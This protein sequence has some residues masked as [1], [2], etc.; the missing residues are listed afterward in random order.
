MDGKLL[1]RAKERLSE[2]SRQNEQAWL[3]RRTAAFRKV[4]ELEKLE[5][6]LQSLVTQAALSALMRGQNVSA[7]VDGMAE[8]SLALQAR[9]RAL[10]RNAGLPENTLDEIYTCPKCHDTGYV[11]GDM[12]SCLQALY[13]EEARKSLSNLLKLGS[14]SFAGFDLSYY[15]TETDADRGVSPRERMRV[16][17]EYCR[18]YAQKFAPGADNLLF[19]GGTGL[20]KTF[21]SACIAREVAERGFSVAYETAVACVS[22]FEAQKFGRGSAEYDRACEQVKRYL[23]CDLM[24]LDDLG[25]EMSGGFSMTA[26]YTLI[27]T[28]LTERKTTI[29]STN[30]SIEDIRKKYS[31]QIASRLEGEYQNLYFMGSDIRR[32]RKERGL[33]R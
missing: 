6:E 13:Q 2:R 33:G 1:A 24:I 25:T 11:D 23:G 27:N 28:R 29:I 32:I 8:K 20:G 14:E 3:D 9:R 30:L 5:K 26:L 18:L 21:L 31:E 22:D 12:C 19:Q 16:V 10:L 7:A 17:L 4:P 15:S